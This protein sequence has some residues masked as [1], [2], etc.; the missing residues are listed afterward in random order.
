MWDENEYIYAVTRVHAR[1]QHLLNSQD[2]GMLTAAA[3]VGEVMRILKEKGW[4]SPADGNA[5]ADGLIAAE[6]QKTW[7]FIQEICGGIPEFSIFRHANDFHNLKAC[8]KLA[9]TEEEGDWNAYCIPFGNVEVEAIVKAVTERNYS[10]LPDALGTAG[11][12]AYE[13]LAHTGNGQLFDMALDVAALEM[14]WQEGSES[15]Y[16]LL[17]TYARILVDTA[18]IRAAVRYQRM[19][20]SREFSDRVIANGGTLG[21][22]ELISAMGASFEDICRLLHATPYAEGIEALRTSMA[23]FECWSDN[24]MME[25]IR[26]QRSNY[27][28]IEPLAAF[29][30]GRENEIRQARLIL[31]AKTN[32]L[33]NTALQERLRVTYA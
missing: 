24:L 10:R 1:E 25:A 2:I 3:D 28:G 14:I 32:G 29:V 20:K 4:G 11:K 30:L 5:G 31:S 8:G 27:F 9:Y 13:I 17:Q 15:K 23:A 18:N 33:S 26:P 21:K 12:R 6:T 19:G 16:P 22:K 7:S